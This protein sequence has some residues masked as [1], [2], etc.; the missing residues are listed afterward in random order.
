MVLLLNSRLTQ[1]LHYYVT[2]SGPWLR[3]KPNKQE[4]NLKFEYFAS[5]KGCRCMF[6][7]T[8]VHEC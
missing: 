5:L 1:C 2:V 3:V 8:S 4:S 7:S 6:L